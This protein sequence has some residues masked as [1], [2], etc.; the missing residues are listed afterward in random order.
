MYEVIIYMEDGSAATTFIAKT[1]SRAITNGYKRCYDHHRE[2]H[3]EIMLVDPQTSQKTRIATYSVGY[4]VRK[5][6]RD[7]RTFRNCIR[8]ELGGWEMSKEGF[9]L[10]VKKGYIIPAPM[11]HHIEMEAGW[12]LI[13]DRF[14][15]IGNY[16]VKRKW[17]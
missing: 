3:F 8:L 13:T 2:D 6:I 1:K 7:L 15:R 9:R 5:A 16:L 17:W 14:K 12:W 10:L 11:P 4:D